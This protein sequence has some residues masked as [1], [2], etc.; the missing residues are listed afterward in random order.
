M[1]EQGRKDGAEGA[2]VW[3][4]WQLGLGF[5]VGVALVVLGAWILF[6]PHIQRDLTRTSCPSEMLDTDSIG[7][8]VQAFARDHGGRYPVHLLEVW[9]Y[10][11]DKNG[12]GGRGTWVDRWGHPYDYTVDPGGQGFTV[13]GLGSDGALGGTGDARDWLHFGGELEGRSGWVEGEPN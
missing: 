10:W 4:R 5:A 7:W 3:T 11:V 9:A 12:D 1:P 13:R 2:R 6:R 8:R